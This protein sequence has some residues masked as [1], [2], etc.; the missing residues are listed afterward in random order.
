VKILLIP[1]YKQVGP[2]AGILC[3]IAAIAVWMSS[4]AAKPAL[5]ERY[6]KTH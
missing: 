2:A 6:L 4:V 3:G 5:A 1:D